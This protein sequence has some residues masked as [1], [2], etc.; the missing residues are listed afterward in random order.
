MLGAELDSLVSVAQK[1]TLNKLL[2]IL[3]NTNHPLHSIMASQR[4]SFSNRLISLEGM[5]CPQNSFV[6]RD[7]RFFNR[8]TY[9]IRLS[10]GYRMASDMV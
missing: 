4:I 9:S 6:L 8:S 10:L 1:R 2:S 7:I 5:L 3:D